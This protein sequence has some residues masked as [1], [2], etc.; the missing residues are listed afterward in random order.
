MLLQNRKEQDENGGD[1]GWRN[2][3]NRRGHS[4]VPSGYETN[5]VGD[6]AQT[7]RAR[8]Q[9]CGS[10][11]RKIVGQLPARSHGML[12]EFA[13]LLSATWRAGSNAVAQGNILGQSAARAR[14]DA[15]RVASRAGAIHR[16]FFAHAHDF[17]QGQSHDRLRH[18]QTSSHGLCGP[19]TLARA[20]VPG[21]S[22]RHQSNR[23]GH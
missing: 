3:R 20:R 2:R 11:H 12:R 8:H 10:T 19:R 1:C 14:R 16:K 6:A 22:A 4:L 18:V 15:R 23:A 5:R 21:F 17:T 13:R 9:L 7:W